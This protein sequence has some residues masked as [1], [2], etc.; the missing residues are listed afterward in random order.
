MN[1]DLQDL[2][3]VAAQF[4]ESEQKYKRALRGL[5]DWQRDREN[6]QI[7]L[8]AKMGTSESYLMAVSLGWVAA[9]V[10]FAREL[11]VFKQYRQKGSDKITINDIT[12]AYLQQREPDYTRQLPMAIYLAARKHHKFPPLLLVAFQGWVYDKTS[13]KW[14]PDEKALEPSLKIEP[15]DSKFSLVDLDVENTLYFALDGQHRLMAIKGLKDLL[16]GRI[17]DK[18]KDG[19]TTGK[20]ITSEEIERYYEESGF[21]IDKLQRIMDDEII[22]IEVI[23]AVQIKETFEEAVSR[24]RN[25]FVDVNE[26]AKKLESGE[27]SMLDENDGFRIVARTLMTKH[28]LFIR[29][30]QLRVD[31]KS[32]QISEKSDYYTTLNTIVNIAKEYLGQMPRFAKWKIPILDSAKIKGI[33][34]VGLARPEVDEISAGFDELGN[35]FTALE[36]LPSHREMLQGTP[37]SKLR[38]DNDGNILFR[39]IAQIALARA[40]SHLLQEGDSTLDLEG[41]MRKLAEREQ[42]GGLKL[43]S[44]ET[45]WF[46][47]LCDPITGRIRRQKFYEILCAR[48]FFYLLVGGTE[49][50]SEREKLRADFFSARMGSTESIDPQA[51]NMEGSLVKYDQFF[52]PNPWQ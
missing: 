9:R 34:D 25:V 28:Q 1:E 6:H 37:A 19:S 40:V 46:G 11:P 16:D 38:K 52:L 44:K 50:A 13:D 47:V 15:L 45:P 31:T 20:S 14:G 7:A 41:L 18:K 5:L 10:R 2:D 51:Y 35:Y 26:N 30:D 29:G 21:D 48:M 3:K 22:G 32:N 23:P 4:L 12:I 33:K 39:P 27:L 36:A 42:R 8:P 43:K 17:Y 49:D 24:L